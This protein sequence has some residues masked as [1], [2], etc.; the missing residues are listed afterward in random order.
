MLS[1]SNLQKNNYVVFQC[2]PEENQLLRLNMFKPDISP[3]GSLPGRGIAAIEWNFDHRGHDK[4]W[5]AETQSL[6]DLF[7]AWFPT[8]SRIPLRIKKMVSCLRLPKVSQS[9]A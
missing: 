8:I 4:P 6:F 2:V 3:A 1:L 7:L 9:P 5:L